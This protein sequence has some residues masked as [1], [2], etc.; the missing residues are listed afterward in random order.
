MDNEAM[1]QW[2]N[3][4]TVLFVGGLDRAHSF[5]GLPILLQ[6]VPRISDV[7]LRIVGDGDLRPQYEQQARALGISDRVEFLGSVSDG[8]LPNMYR[9]SDVLVLP[10]IGRSEA[11]GVV[12]LEAMASGI[13]VIASDLPGVRTVVADGETGFLAPPGDVSALADRIG[14]LARDSEQRQRM[15][16]AARQRVEERYDWERVMERWLKIYDGLK[17]P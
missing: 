1:K 9:Q 10:S 3:T 13:P 15:S 16:A 7:R 17:C 11:F 2:N 12:L 8:E 6:A 4:L 14:S 5:K